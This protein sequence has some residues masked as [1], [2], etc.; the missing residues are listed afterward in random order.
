MNKTTTKYVGKPCKRCGNIIR[1]KNHNCVVCA[2]ERTASWQRINRDRMIAK[3][4]LRYAADNA[5]RR[6]ARKAQIEGQY[7]Q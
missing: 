6:A 2:N 7:I 4:R 1:Y 3:R 5:K